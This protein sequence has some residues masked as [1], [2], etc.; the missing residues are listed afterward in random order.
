MTG[1]ARK[2]RTPAHHRRCSSTVELIER[3]GKWGRMFWRKRRTSGVKNEPKP[4]V[5][6][7][8]DDE[9]VQQIML[10]TR[11]D[12]SIVRPMMGPHPTSSTRRAIWAITYFFCGIGLPFL[13]LTVMVLAFRDEL[14]RDGYN[15]W[16]IPL[17]PTTCLLVLIVPV[18]LWE[19]LDAPRLRRNLR[20]HPQAA[21]K[22]LHELLARNRALGINWS[23]SVHEVRK[24][25]RTKI[26]EDTTTG[27]TPMEHSAQVKS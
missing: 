10:R 6:P 25:L 4:I 21:R 23:M 14:V 15:M 18:F 20:K 13:I 12:P 16:Q 26:A 22:V 8:S 2:A 7:E 9:V 24:E 1:R 17:L 11:A 3:G 19:W 5:L 27:H